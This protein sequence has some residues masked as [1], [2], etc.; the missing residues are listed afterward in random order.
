MEQ[1]GDVHLQYGDPVNPT[2][3]PWSYGGLR[4]LDPMS[5]ARDPVRARY[6]G[7]GKMQVSGVRHHSVPVSARHT[8]DAVVAVVTALIGVMQ[9]AALI[10]VMIAVVTAIGITVL[11][12]VE[13]A[14]L[15]VI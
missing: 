5:V 3:T 4:K 12:V 1:E 15:I 10:A 8:G 13:L 6:E 14:A 2:R 11:I 9:I 7:R